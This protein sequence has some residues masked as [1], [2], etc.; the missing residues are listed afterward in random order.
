MVM[1]YSL[2]LLLPYND[3]MIGGRWSIY[4]TRHIYNVICILVMIIMHAIIFSI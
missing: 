2:F 4:S 3:L 1:D